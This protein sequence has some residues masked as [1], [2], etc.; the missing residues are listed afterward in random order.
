[1]IR[2]TSANYIAVVH[3][4]LNSSDYR[5]KL[6]EYRVNPIILPDDLYFFPYKRQEIESLYL[7]GGSP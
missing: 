6:Q 3:N 1:M 2:I 5:P 4:L 7:Y